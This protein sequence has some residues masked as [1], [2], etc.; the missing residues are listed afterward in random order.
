MSSSDESILK[1]TVIMNQE[2][3]H[4]SSLLEDLTLCISFSDTGVVQSVFTV[5]YTDS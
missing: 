1:S 5:A 4:F 2:K 3:L